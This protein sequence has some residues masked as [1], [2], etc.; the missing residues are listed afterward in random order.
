MQ[1]IGVRD[2]TVHAVCSLAD[3]WFYTTTT[4]DDVFVRLSNPKSNK[5][6]GQVVTNM[7]N[8]DFFDL[9][10]EEDTDDDFIANDSGG[11]SI[12]D[13]EEDLVEKLVLF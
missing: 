9:P 7:F 5:V 3:M 4:F 8:N 12:D 2:L 6:D 11:S 13:E 1:H 10:D